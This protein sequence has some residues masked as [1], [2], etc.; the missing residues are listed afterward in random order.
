MSSTVE[1]TV[2]ALYIDP[3]GPYMRLKGVD[4]WDAERDAR[5]YR[6]PHPV[7]A[8]PPCKRWG[9]FFHGSPS[10]PHEHLLG[11]D[12]GCFAHALWAVRTFGGVLEHPAGSR[13]WEWFG[14]PQ[15][16]RLGWGWSAHEDRYGG[17]SIVVNQGR[18]GHRARKL[19]WLYA[20]LPQF[21]QVD[22]RD[23]EVG[24]MVPVEHM[25]RAERRLT[26]EP[27][28]ELLLSM[29]RSCLDG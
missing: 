29:A 4:A 17:R 7:V 26:P 25:T 3:K 9:N 12:D 8:H 6:G 22:G 23:T 20:V 5:K 13:A 10:K 21:P 16:A 18:Y 11:D 14:L 2:A 24:S 15:P 28:K 27:F 1:G 19:T